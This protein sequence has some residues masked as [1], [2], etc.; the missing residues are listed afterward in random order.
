MSDF[1][2]YFII[3]I[4]TLESNLGIDKNQN[5]HAESELELYLIKFDTQP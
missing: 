5:I 3:I 1:F 2:Y 4:F